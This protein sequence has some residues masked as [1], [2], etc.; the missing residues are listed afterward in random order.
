M[1]EKRDYYEVLGVSKGATDKEIKKAYRT[2][3]RK[4]HPDLNKDNPKAAEEKF[5]EVTEAYEVL[6]DAKKRA[7]YDQFGHAAFGAGGG[8]GAGAGGFGGFGGFGDFGG[9]SSGGFGGFNG[10]DIFE[11]FFGGG[12]TR[13]ARGPR[14][15]SDLRYDI[16]ITFEEAAFGKEIELTIPRKEECATCHG[17]GAEPGTSSETC[18]KCHGTGQIKE[19]HNTILGQMMQQSVCDRCGGTGKII[20]N[21]CHTCHGKGTVDAKSK[22]RVKIPA[23]VDNGSRIRVSG[24]G[25]AGQLG[26]GYGD[27]YVYISVKPHKFFQ[28]DGANVICEVPISFIQ[29]ALG[30]K[31]DVPTLEGEVDMTIPA[32]VQPGAILRLSGR[33]IQRLHG[34]GKG[35]QLVRLKIFTPQNL[36]DEQKKLLEQFSKTMTASNMHKEEKTWKDWFK[37]WKSFFH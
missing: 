19:V 12:A 13:K 15:G 25:Q 20:K 31:I 30:D 17:S 14:R 8:A 28:R 10:E 7:Q 26:G 2:L 1:S 32:G 33:G 16:S 22:I 18:P 27:L 36:S 3:A 4:Y 24:A 35:D 29:A 9:F 11:S 37:N 5:K 23:G 6:S 34:R 21:P